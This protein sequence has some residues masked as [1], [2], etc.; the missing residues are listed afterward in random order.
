MST[1]IEL[2][3]NKSL[4]PSMTWVASSVMVQE[5]ERKVFKVVNHDGSESSVVLT[6]EGDAVT[7]R[8]E[9][10]SNGNLIVAEGETEIYIKL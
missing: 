3:R 4:V 7:A 6:R 9:D 5:G 10:A 2:P 1:D 8:F